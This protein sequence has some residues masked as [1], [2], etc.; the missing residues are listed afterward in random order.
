VLTGRADKLTLANVARL[1]GYASPGE[2]EAF[3][4]FLGAM[5]D[6]KIGYGHSTE[7]YHRSPH[8]RTAE[9]FAQYVSLTNGP[10]KALARPLLH[11]IAPRCCKHFDELIEETANGG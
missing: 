7:Y 8:F 2:G 9:M 10:N 11:A 4:D 3:L 6:N 5:T 1:V